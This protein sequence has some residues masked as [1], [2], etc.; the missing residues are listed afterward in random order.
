[1][2]AFTFA[3]VKQNRTIVHIR[4]NGTDK[5]TLP[6]PLSDYTLFGH[7]LVRKMYKMKIII[8]IRVYYDRHESVSQ[9][10]SLALS[11]NSWSS[12]VLQMMQVCFRY[13]FSFGY[14]KGT[15]FKI[16]L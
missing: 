2:E 6:Q 11:N 4:I 15:I 8:L 1:M 13:V 9:N 7:L 14:L 16:Y 12:Q 5:Q 3:H 10:L